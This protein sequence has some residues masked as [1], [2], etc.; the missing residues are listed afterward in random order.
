[1]RIKVPQ[2]KFH[3]CVSLL[4]PSRPIFCTSKNAD[5]SDH[6]AP[7]SWLS[8]ASYKPPKVALAL[9]NER[10]ANLSQSLVNIRRE[11]EF[12]INLPHRG[13]EQKLVQ[14]SFLQGDYACK[15]DRTGFTRLDTQTVK[16]VSIEECKASLSCRV[17]RLLEDFGD[18][19]LI[20]AD[21]VEASYEEECY[22]DDLC[23]RLDQMEPLISLR[24]YRFDDHQRHE[25]IDSAKSYLVDVY[26]DENHESWKKG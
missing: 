7:F 4:Q 20:L 18:H 3:L 15:F 24:E 2:D 22:G 9:Q 12:V 6:V 19:T 8:P 1:M 16:P 10:S 23:P 11:G 14:A 26:Y 25:F 5:G 21:I 13:Q 17:I